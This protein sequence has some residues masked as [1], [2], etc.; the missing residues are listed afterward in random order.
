M[1][2]KFLIELN[3]EKVGQMDNWIVMLL[4]IGNYY[5]LSANMIQPQGVCDAYSFDYYPNIT[6]DLKCKI[7]VQW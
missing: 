6:N 3:R 1:I 2:F 4:T 5:L 7:G